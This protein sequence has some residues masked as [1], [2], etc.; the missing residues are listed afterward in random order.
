MRT[1]WQIQMDYRRAMDAARRLRAI[2]GSMDGNANSLGGA[3]S[4]INGSWDGENSDV[5]IEKGRK[6][7]SNIN[8][9]A[10]GIRRT[11]SAIEKIA[12]R[13]RDAELAAISVADN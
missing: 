12:R 9:T 10:D 1:A 7:Q 5:Y 4:S 3:L 6:V 2:A 13:T 11:A 8:T